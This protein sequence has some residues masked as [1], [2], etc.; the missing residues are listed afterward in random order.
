V[1]HPVRNLVELDV[2]ITLVVLGVHPG[3]AQVWVAGHDLRCRDDPQADPL[4]ATKEQV[5]GVAKRELGIWRVKGSDMHVVQAAGAPHKDLPHG[6]SP[7]DF[8]FRHT[9]TLLNAR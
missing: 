6:L 1:P 2:A 8:E 4:L 9:D 3:T 5:A 7:T